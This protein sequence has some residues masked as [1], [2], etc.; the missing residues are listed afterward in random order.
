[1][2]GAQPAPTR[3]QPPPGEIPDAIDG[4]FVFVAKERLTKEARDK[5][6]IGIG[7][8]GAWIMEDYIKSTNTA[9]FI[10]TVNDTDQDHRVM[11]DVFRP[12]HRKGQLDVFNA[13]MP[14]L[15]PHA[16]ASSQQGMPAQVGIKPWLMGS[17]AKTRR[18]PTQGASRYLLGHFFNRY[19]TNPL[20]SKLRR[21]G[22]D[23]VPVVLDAD[24]ARELAWGLVQ[25]TTFVANRSPATGAAPGE[26]AVRVRQRDPGESNKAAAAAGTITVV[27]DG[28]MVRIPVRSIEPKQLSQEKATTDLDIVLDT[29]QGTAERVAALKAIGAACQGAGG[30]DMFLDSFSKTHPESLTNFYDLAMGLTGLHDDLVDEVRTL[31]P[32]VLGTAACALIRG[33]AAHLAEHGLVFNPRTE[34]LS[35]PTPAGLKNGTVHGRVSKP[36]GRYVEEDYTPARMVVWGTTDRRVREGEIPGDVI[37][38]GEDFD[39][40]FFD[41]IIAGIERR[42]S[43]VQGTPPYPFEITQK[44][45]YIE[46]ACACLAPL[47]DAI[48]DAQAAVDADGDDASIVRHSNMLHILWERIPRLLKSCVSMMR[49]PLVYNDLMLPL[50]RLFSILTRPLTIKSLFL[51]DVAAKWMAEGSVLAGD[52]SKT[53]PSMR[54]NVATKEFDLPWRETYAVKFEDFVD[55]IIPWACST[56]CNMCWTTKQLRDQA[57]EL[58]SKFKF[59]WS[60]LLDGDRRAYQCNVLNRLKQYCIEP[61]VYRSSGNEI[62]P[63]CA[64]DCFRSCMGDI[65]ETAWEEATSIAYD[66]MSHVVYLKAFKDSKKVTPDSPFWNIF[67]GSFNAVGALLDGLLNGSD[68]SAGKLAQLEKDIDHAYDG[69][70]AKKTKDKWEFLQEHCFDFVHEFRRTFFWSAEGCQ[71]SNQNLE[72]Q[73]QASFKGMLACLRFHNVNF[74]DIFER[75]ITVDVFV[76]VFESLR[77]AALSPIPGRAEVGKKA[78]LGAAKS[79]NDTFRYMVA[80]ASGHLLQ[81]DLKALKKTSKDRAKEPDVDALERVIMLDLDVHICLWRGS[82]G[83]ESEVAVKKALCVISDR[84]PGN[85]GNK[86]GVL[87]AGAIEQILKSR[88]VLLDRFSILRWKMDLY[89][90]AKFSYSDSN[91]EAL[92]LPAMDPDTADAKPIAAL[93]MLLEDKAS[94]E[95]Y[96]RE[97]FKIFRVVCRLACTSKEAKVR[98]AATELLVD[99]AI[100]PVD[101]KSWAS[102]RG[103]KYV[104]EHARNGIGDASKAV[105]EK[106]AEALPTLALAAT[107]REGE[108]LHTP[109]SWLK[110]YAVAAR[111]ANFQSEDLKSILDALTSKD[112][113]KVAPATIRKMIDRAAKVAPPPTRQDPV[114]ASLTSV[115]GTLLNA[116][117]ADRAAMRGAS[118][119]PPVQESA[120]APSDLDS[121]MD[122]ALLD[123]ISTQDDA[124]MWWAVQEAARQCISA[125]LRTHYGNASETLTFIERSLGEVRRNQ[126]PTVAGARN[127][128]RTDAQSMTATWLLLE[129]VDALERQMYNA[130]EGTLSLPPPGKSAASFFRRNKH[131]CVDWLRRIKEASLGAAK[132]C[133]NVAMGA[134]IALSRV[135]AAIKAQER[136]VDKAAR[137][138]AEAPARILELKSAVSD[139]NA[140]LTQAHKRHGLGAARLERARQTVSERMNANK[141]KQEI[142]KAKEKVDELKDEVKDAKEEVSVAYRDKNEAQEKLKD[143]ERKSAG[144]D[145]DSEKDAAA[146]VFRA[147]GDAAS[148]L[149]SFGEPDLLIGLADWCEPRLRPA[150]A[151]VWLPP[152]SDDAFTTST[153]GVLDWVRAA[154]LEAGGRHEQAA[155]K[156]RHMLETP[157]KIGPAS[158]RAAAKRL[159]HAYASVCDWDGLEEWRKDLRKIQR[160]VGKTGSIELASALNDV[161]AKPE[162]LGAWANFDEGQ[163]DK[164][165][166]PLAISEKHATSPSAAVDVLNHATQRLLEELLV[167]VY[168]EGAGESPDKSER[169]VEARKQ[170]QTAMKRMQEP[171]RLS[172]LMGSPAVT[173]ALHIELAAADAVYGA[174]NEKYCRVF[175]A[176]RGSYDVSTLT[177]WI[178]LCRVLNALSIKEKIG[179]WPQIHWPQVAFESLTLSAELVAE[180][181]RCAG[182]LGNFKV[183]RKIFKRVGQLSELD[184]ESDCVQFGQFV[185]QF[186]KKLD[187]IESDAEGTRTSKDEQY[188]SICKQYQSAFNALVLPRQWGGGAVVAD[189][190]DKAYLVPLVTDSIQEMSRTVKSLADD[191]SG[192][193]LYGRDGLFGIELI[194]MVYTFEEHMPADMQKRVEPTYGELL[195]AYSQFEFSLDYAR[196]LDDF[197]RREEDDP[198]RRTRRDKDPISAAGIEDIDGV[199]GEPTPLNPGADVKEVTYLLE[200]AHA[201]ARFLIQCGENGE[202]GSFS[203]SQTRLPG[204]KP[205]PGEGGGDLNLYHAKVRLLNFANSQQIGES[206]GMKEILGS[207]PTAYWRQCIPELITMLHSDIEPVR[208]NATDLLTRMAKEHPRALSYAIAVAAAAA[209]D[210]ADAAGEGFEVGGFRSNPEALAAVRER[211]ASASRAL[212][213]IGKVKSAL[214][215]T[216]PR[217]FAD[218]T[219]VVSELGRLAVLHDE[220]LL[221]SLQDLHGDVTSRI[222]SVSESSE[223]I[224]D[225]M[226]PAVAELDR[227][228]RDAL[229]GAGFVTPHVKSFAKKYREGLL[230]AVNEFKGSVAS[231][232]SNGWR[233]VKEQMVQLARG[234]QRKRELRLKNLS[235]SLAKLESRPG[236][237]AAPMPGDVGGDVDSILVDIVSVGSDVTVLPTKS[238]PKRITLLGSDG[239]RRVFLLKGNEDLRLDARLMRFGSVVNAALLSDPES[240]KRSLE[241]STYSVTPLAGNS[242]L[243]QWVEKATPMS[244]IFAGWQRRTRA[245]AALPK[246]VPPPGS[247]PDPEWRP[248]EPPEAATTRPL[249]LFYNRVSAALRAAGVLATA[250]RRDWP[251]DVLHDTVQRM[252]AEVPQDYLHRELWCGAPTSSAWLQK[253]VRH[254]RSVA[255]ASVVGHLIGLGD[256]HLDNVLV[257][258]TTGAVVHIDY[259]VSFDRGLTLPVSFFF[260]L[261]PCWRFV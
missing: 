182:R 98:M 7:A 44:E 56:R 103:I 219:L 64:S 51:D 233:A 101:S 42:L 111:R 54:I 15:D 221:T 250:K 34:K 208:D 86:K 93:R 203:R 228:V 160:D 8:D 207:I 58:L 145:T 229:S 114:A 69:Q 255:T 10:C 65:G 155:E 194:R 238:R 224:E 251:Q 33:F 150:G 105:R 136:R 125:R 23:E 135:Q 188:V 24:E 36:F 37:I 17:D 153:E 253:S 131:I 169:I 32:A 74:E 195:H 2:G 163:F 94:A 200:A 213:A 231:D 198:K 191:L 240:R 91:A 164:R 90:T 239:T 202:A 190:T 11:L 130:Y 189:P 20:T 124:A 149:V 174:V 259:N 201:Y 196:F 242:G 206:D 175:G 247:D 165:I 121:D 139:A 154:A 71:V 55:A 102:M 230:D 236:G 50:F 116:A 27:R 39:M 141:S 97:S 63:L 176:V 106:W 127:V 14:S 128:S 109:P 261:F 161:G 171:L 235:P 115:G 48:V 57:N 119:T 216:D 72:P 244:A 99:R 170:L 84:F 3:G 46:A 225:V 60:G 62:N 12:V 156:Y 237:F 166:S 258:L 59:K 89:V 19:L 179:A 95:V 178:K 53:F 118:E 112:M 70:K 31:A 211:F 187:F 40:H 120:P 227:L 254:A 6:M 133:G 205:M 122:T 30:P 246:V 52:V 129:F 173:Q 88:P 142:D 143:L 38:T 45:F 162:L 252:R 172:N 77:F 21:L 76:D 226:R 13:D 132:S 223:P 241:Y 43:G 180:L 222:A 158:A 25:A 159:T 199:C 5:R 249:D 123:H 215:A 100:V 210:E 29:K 245:A 66:L 260:F 67:L 209:D 117:A 186:R 68:G 212:E 146:L 151:D 78:Y 92:L 18:S 28:R 183:F 80:Y 181:T 138:R 26:V 185:Q 108:C 168:P 204:S 148:L 220:E 217:L 193:D 9:V 147:I 152:S 256:R 47:M 137:R 110:H 61:D 82:D 126:T 41:V 104:Y 81:R 22:K 79:S 184:L 4:G 234:L 75:P 192:D 107:W 85:P 16:F 87:Q 177:P 167:P 49:D 157:E 144:N 35:V 232:P 96:L 73:V 243:I 134:N 257:N 218:V 83:T 140:R 248:P 1:M 214:S 113:T 197:H